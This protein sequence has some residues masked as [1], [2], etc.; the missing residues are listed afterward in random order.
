MDIVPDMTAQAFIRSFQRFMS[1]RSFPVQ[2]VSDNAKT[3]KI[4]AKI[5]ADTLEIPE[6]K[7]YFAY[8]SVDWAL[9]LE[10]APW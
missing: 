9:N 1:R 7:R 4:S 5:V 3:F 8:V 6:V 10:R 2:I